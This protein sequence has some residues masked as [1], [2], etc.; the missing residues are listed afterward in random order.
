MRVQRV[1]MPVTDAMSCTVVDEDGN[2]VEP[3]REL[4][5]LLVRVDLGS[6]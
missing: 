3:D 1:I 5:R 4:P 2:P 6:K